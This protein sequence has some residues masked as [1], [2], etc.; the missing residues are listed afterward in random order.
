LISQIRIDF[1]PQPPKALRSFDLHGLSSPSFEQCS[2]PPFRASNLG[3]SAALS[4]L[5]NRVGFE[6]F[7]NEAGAAE[8]ARYVKAIDFAPSDRVFD[9]AFGK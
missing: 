8:A 6:S 2:R 3:S 5:S 1:H 9:E 4:G 7:L